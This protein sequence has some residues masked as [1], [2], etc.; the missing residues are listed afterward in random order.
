M[1]DQKWQS[2]KQ[3]KLSKENEQSLLDMIYKIAEIF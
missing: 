3:N 2:K 1:L